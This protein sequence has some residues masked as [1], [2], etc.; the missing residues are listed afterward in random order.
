VKNFH[1]FIAETVTPQ[2]LLWGVVQ[3]TVSTVPEFEIVASTDATPDKFALRKTAG[4][5]GIT[6]ETTNSFGVGGDFATTPTEVASS[7]QLAMTTD[8]RIKPQ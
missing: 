8:V 5:S 7:K 2:K 4:N 1:F 6:D 3:F